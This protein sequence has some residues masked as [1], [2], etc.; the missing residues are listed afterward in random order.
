MPAMKLHLQ[1][2]KR[3]NV[4]SQ[5]DFILFRYKFK[6]IHLLPKLTAGD[7][8]LNEPGTD[9]DRRT[10]RL[11]FFFHSSV[12]KASIKSYPPSSSGLKPVD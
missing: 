6:S 9:T 11:L 5:L 8:I 10:D 3:L 7:L 4:T 2:F 1:P 12:G